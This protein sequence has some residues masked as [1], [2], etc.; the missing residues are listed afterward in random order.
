MKSKTISIAAGVLFVVSQV[1]LFLGLDSEQRPTTIPFCTAAMICFAVSVA[2]WIFGLR[3]AARER[4]QR[5]LS[6]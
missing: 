5:D 3:V 1:F 2:V 6:L 4:R